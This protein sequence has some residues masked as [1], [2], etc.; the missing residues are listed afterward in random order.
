MGGGS[1]E[2]LLLRVIP[3]VRNSG[4]YRVQSLCFVCQRSGWGELFRREGVVSEDGVE[5]WARGVLASPPL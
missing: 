3:A 2:V 4:G 1:E 5:G